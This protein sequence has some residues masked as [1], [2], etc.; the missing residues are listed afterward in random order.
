MTKVAAPTLEELAEKLEGVGDELSEE[1]VEAA[2]Q[3]DLDAILNLLGQHGVD[4]DEIDDK[5]EALLEAWRLMGQ[6][7]SKTSDQPVAQYVSKQVEDD[8]I[9]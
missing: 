6:K 1:K 8:R 7:Q 5:E 3:R 4:C 9:V 2:Y